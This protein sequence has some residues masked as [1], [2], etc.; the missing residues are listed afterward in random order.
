MLDEEFLKSIIEDQK[1]RI[2][3]QEK[4][5]GELQTTIAELNRA[6]YG[7]SSESTKTPAVE[8]AP[9]TGETKAVTIKEH[10]RPRKPKSKR[11]DLYGNLP[12]EKIVSPVP[13]NERNCP[14]CNAL[15]VPMNP[16][17]VR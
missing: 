9:S 7:I 5:I 3:S 12:I 8:E 17:F 6:L 13:E 15:M 4:L 2:A 16:T 10:T 14:W 11:E 1:S